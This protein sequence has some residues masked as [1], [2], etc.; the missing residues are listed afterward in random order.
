ME[1]R[2]VTQNELQSVYALCHDLYVENGYCIPQPDGMLKH[3]EHLNT[4]PETF[5]IG[6]FDPELIG[7]LSMTIDSVAGLPIAHAFHETLLHTR[8]RCIIENK[9]MGV[10]WRLVTRQRSLGIVLGMI[11][12]II[13]LA[14][15]NKIDLLLYEFNPKHQRVYEKLLDMEVIAGPIS[16][17]AVNDAPAVLMKSEMHRLILAWRKRNRA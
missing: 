17:P 2:L 5:V 16:D 7:T 15:E 4:I 1:I 6:A 14:M 8:F 13:D 3:Y 11:N 12:K 10:C 9:K